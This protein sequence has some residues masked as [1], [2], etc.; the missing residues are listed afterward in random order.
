[1]SNR[2]LWFLILALVWIIGF[3][4]WAYVYVPWLEKKR[5]E[6]VKQNNEQSVELVAVDEKNIWLKEQSEL[7]PSEAELSSQDKINDL[8]M[9]ME[10][11]KII[12]IWNNKF[13]FIEN[14][15]SLNLFLDK[16]LVSIFPF[17]A[18]DLLSISKIYSS[19]LEFFIS[20]NKDYYIYDSKIDKLSFLDLWVAVNYIKKQNNNYLVN[21]KEWIFV[22]DIVKNEIDYNDIFRDFIYFND[23]Y[24]GII[25]H[26][27]ERRQK[28]FSIYPQEKNVIFY[29]NPSSKER[30]ILYLSSLN[31]TKI[32]TYETEIYFEENNNKT[33]KLENYK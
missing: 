31:L 33:Y 8:K 32:F 17:V 16:K 3:F 26:T 14:E 19:E 24:I 20:I 6:L 12:E 21:T 7:K 29:Y 13:N 4:Y 27:D 23:W 2:V 1:M 5:Q 28:N 15:D 10:S 11:Y 30:K 22:F 18:E 25:E 9:D